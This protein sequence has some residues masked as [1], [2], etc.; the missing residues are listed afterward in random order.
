M[1]QGIKNMGG[2]SPDD[3]TLGQIAERLPNLGIVT[4][5]NERQHVFTRSDTFF[6]QKTTLTLTKDGTQATIVYVFAPNW[7]SWALGICFFPLG[8]LIF[9]LAYNAKIDFDNSVALL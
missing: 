6:T 8:C 5:E 1:F 7:V 4:M 2:L 9:L 3:G